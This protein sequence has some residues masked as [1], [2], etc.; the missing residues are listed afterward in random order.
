MLPRINIR[1]L[2]LWLALAPVALL[3]SGPLEEVQTYSSIR[4]VSLEKLVAGQIEGARIPAEGG[5]LSISTET[6]FAVP[7]PPARVVD[8]MSDTIS[9][10]TVQASDTLDVEL[11]LPVSKPPKESDFARLKLVGD[12]A[13]RQLL[14]QSA[15]GTGSGLNLNAVEAANLAKA[16]SPDAIEAAWHKLLVGR[17]RIFQNQGWVGSSA[18]DLGNKSFNQHQEIVRLLKTMPG[19]LERF[20]DSIGSAMTARLAE[21]SEP[22]KFYWETSRIQ[23]DRVITLGAVYSRKVSKNRW[24]VVEPTYYVSSK[25]YTSLI[26]YEILPLEFDGKSGSLVWRGD[27]VI[28]P[29]IGVMKG[30]ER[31]AA[32]NITLLEVRKSVRS[33]AEECRAAP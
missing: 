33:F 30:I 31:M 12:A 20:K 13:S 4:K 22:V 24:Q 29:T 19:I 16:D 17:A 8:L 23:G 9:A 25:Y 7:L 21:G 15:K 1:I 14:A 27:F 28:T 32:E 3:N 6:L 26:L 5:E 11:H 18:Y 2:G 10:T